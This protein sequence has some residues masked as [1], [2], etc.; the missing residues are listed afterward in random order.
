MTEREIVLDV[1]TERE[2]TGAYSNILIKKALDRKEELTPHQRSFIKRLAEGTIERQIELDSVIGRYL[3]NPDQK[4]KPLVRC[5]LRMSI[6]QIYYMDSVPDHAACN[7]AV[8]ILKKRHI[9]HAAGFVN[10]VLRQVCR[11]KAAPAADPA[12]ESAA[13]RQTSAGRY[14]MPEFIVG[15]WEEAY[16]RQET[17]KLL[18]ALL[19][20]R[21]VCIRLDLGYPEETLDKAMDELAGLGVEV[22]P[23]RWLPYCRRLKRIRMSVAELPGFSDGLYTVQDESSMLA[24]EALGITPDNTGAGTVIYDLCASPGGKAM[25]IASKAPSAKVYAFDLTRARTD[26]IRRNARRMKCGNLTVGEWD[27]ETFDPSRFEGADYVLCDLPCSGLGVTGRKQDIKYNVTEAKIASLVSL[28]KRILKTA[29]RYV[30]P[31]GVLVYSTCTIDRAENEKMADYIEQ[32]LG[33][34]RSALSPYLPEGI[35]AGQEKDEGRLQ[36]LPH[37]HD[38]DG[39]FM[40]RFTK[41]AQSAAAD[42]EKV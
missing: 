36:L 13:A 19:E 33:M 27:A 37:I 35:M 42:D 30:K 17:E 5:L 4:M 14:S 28:Q 6:Y 23:G 40:A 38:T 31:G 32:K 1:L 16:G 9:D 29:V 39:F 8:R 20:P 22:M 7:E 3:K 21:P 10:A 15:M 11:Q 2:R 41:P 25:H 34:R 12:K 18:A 26:L 24:V